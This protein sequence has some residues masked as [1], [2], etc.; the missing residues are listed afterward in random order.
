MLPA[1]PCLT[2]RCAPSPPAAPFPQMFELLG[3]KSRPA[4]INY[5]SGNDSSREFGE[6]QQGGGCGARWWRA[7]GRA[8]W[9]PRALPLL[10][11]LLPCC[12]VGML[13]SLCSPLPLPVPQAAPAAAAASTS[14]RTPEP[15]PRAEPACLC[16]GGHSHRTAA[17]AKPYSS[18]SFVIPPLLCS[19]CSLRLLQFYT[20]P[21]NRERLG[22]PQRPVWRDSVTSP[23]LRSA[24]CHGLLRLRSMVDRMACATPILAPPLRASSCDKCMIKQATG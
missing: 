3:L 14:T 7:V 2:R 17:S 20:T 10:R 22:L 23:L 21:A 1:R 8:G 13:T 5:A 16:I 11:R 12:P 15:R 9:L 24:G 18:R 19:C 4:F 6:A